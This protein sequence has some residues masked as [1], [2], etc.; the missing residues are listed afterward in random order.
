ML[1]DYIKTRK[2]EPSWYEG[3]NC[4]LYSR[5]FERI[6]GSEIDICKR[7]AVGDFIVVPVTVREV[8]ATILEITLFLILCQMHHFSKT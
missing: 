5:D 8:W 1:E 6:I 4:S 3:E 7:N 2:L